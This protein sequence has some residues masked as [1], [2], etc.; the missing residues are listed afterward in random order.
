MSASFLDRSGVAKLGAGQ[1][2]HWWLAAWGAG[3]GDLAWSPSPRA[4]VRDR[5]PSHWGKPET[6]QTRVASRF[7]RAA[8]PSSSPRSPSSRATAPKKP[9]EQPLTLINPEISRNAGARRSTGRRLTLDSLT[10]GL[11]AKTDVLVVAGT[12]LAGTRLLALGA[13]AV[14]VGERRDGVSLGLLPRWVR[15]KQE[16]WS[17]ET[18]AIGDAGGIRTRRSRQAASGTPSRFAQ[19]P[20]CLSSSERAGAR[21]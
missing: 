20:C 2:C 14:G 10:R 18:R 21:V 11:E 3:W 8:R 4:P 15:K 17:P 12:V 19:P 9:G 1:K 7:A 13:E 6:A 16:R 5:P